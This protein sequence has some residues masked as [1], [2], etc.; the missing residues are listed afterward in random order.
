MPGLLLDEGNGDN[1][2]GRIPVMAG[3]GL[4]RLGQT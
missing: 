2:L 4:R 1:G 3:M